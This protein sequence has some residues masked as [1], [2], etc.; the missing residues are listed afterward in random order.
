[1][2]GALLSLNCP[3]QSVIRNTPLVCSLTVNA[4][5][6][7]VI[8]VSNI[9]QVTVTFGDPAAGNKIYTFT[10]NSA[11]ISITYTYTTASAGVPFTM[12]AQLN[13]ATPKSKAVTIP[14]TVI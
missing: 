8:G 13:N 5:I 11:T 3:T 1:M 9:F 14:I 12:S 4:N 7:G 6:I 2:I 10:S